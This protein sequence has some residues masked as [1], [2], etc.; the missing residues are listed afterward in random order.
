VASTTTGRHQAVAAIL[1]FLIALVVFG[2]VLQHRGPD[3]TADEPHYLI[4]SWSLLHDHDVDLAD[5]YADPATV[6]RL[7][8]QPTIDPHAY[9]YRHNG[10]LISDHQ[11]GLPLLVAPGLA[12]GGRR[13]AEIELVVLGAL[14]AQQ[15]FRLLEERRL[16]RRWMVWGAWVAVV[17]SLPIVAM[18]GRIF[19][20]VPAALLVVVA[21]RLLLRDATRYD[22]IGASLAIAAL[23]WLHV[24]YA[25]IALC[26]FAGLGYRIVEP[27]WRRRT[28]H[29]QQRWPWTELVC[30]AAPVVSIV[31]L[32][33]AFR[34][35]YGSPWLTAP[36]H[37]PPG[38]NEARPVSDASSLYRYGFGQLLSPAFGWFPAAPLHALALVAVGIVAVR[39]R[40]VT[41]WLA[42][43]GLLYLGAAATI[44]PGQNLQARF[45][46]VVIP[47]IALPLLI[48]VA[49]R[50]R[51]L[52]V[53]AAAL[54]AVT[55]AIGLEAALHPNALAAS[56]NGDVALPFEHQV[57]RLFPNLSA[58]PKNTEAAF[59]AVDL[60]RHVGRVVTD[61]AA[62]NAAPAASPSAGDQVVEAGPTDG[63][64]DLA[65]G[66]PMTLAAGSY[67]AR[68]RVS[69]TTGTAGGPA[70]IVEI[71]GNNRVVA[72][73]ELDGDTGGYV[74][75]ALRVR[76][77]RPTK[78]EWR[79]RASGGGSVR[80][81]AVD[82][83]PVDAELAR[84]FGTRFPDATRTGAWVLAGAALL[85]ALVVADRRSP[86]SARHTAGRAAGAVH[87]GDDS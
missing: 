82:V 1:P 65:T 74:T 21:V 44:D 79:A 30:L 28:S 23:P 64:G 50:P 75:I 80:L 36:Y 29:D 5:N 60:T 2:A 58:G 13:G 54:G 22:R 61:P 20:D 39:H 7:Y 72:G 4:F 56:P 33:I 18:A 63:D 27:R 24:R 57:G 46:V 77:T 51:W 37:F 8:G 25:V 31:A 69:A 15:L 42:V 70:G 76:F 35:W 17:G 43:L 52:V 85:V 38:A 73:R 68:F 34:A 45:M 87:G 6:Q 14:L 10:A 11:I 12:V 49:S 71:A 32:M 53:P 78:I 47:L 55:L 40:L 67:V 26:L 81:A 59:A 83:H 86:R 48:A 3:V 62:V 41:A 66:W 19:P 16:G 9:D 84:A